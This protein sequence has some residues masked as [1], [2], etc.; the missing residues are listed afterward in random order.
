M[1]RR[2]PGLVARPDDR[3]SVDL[4]EAKGL[5]SDSRGVAV[6]TM[7]SRGTGLVRVVVTGATLGP[8][9]FAN[10]FQTT[11]LVPNITFEVAAGALLTAL[12]VP[13]LVQAIEHA[14]LGRAQEIA[15][16]LLGVVIVAFLAA[17]ALVLAAGP[18]IVRLLTSA[19]DDPVVASTT[20]REVWVLLALVAPQIALYGVAGIG[21]AAQNSR[22]QFA[23]AAAAPALENIGLIVTLLASAAWFGVGRD[24][25][26]VP[27]AELV[28]LGLGS[29]FAVAAHAALQLFGARRAGIRLRPRW[30]WNDPDVRA[31][32]RRSVPAVGAGALTGVWTFSV[33]VGAGVVPGGVIAFQVALSFYNLAMAIGARAVGTATLPRLA[34][35]GGAGE[36]GP[37]RRVYEH[38]LLATWSVALPAAVGVA[39]LARPLATALAF[40]RIASP[41]GIDLLSFA[42]ASLGFALAGGSVF[43]FARQAAYARLDTRSPL[44]AAA[45]RTT[46]TL[47]GVAIAYVGMRGS[48]SA[49]V[50]IGVAVTVGDS[51]A[52]W[53]QHRAVI[54]GAPPASTPFRSALRRPVIMTLVIAGPSIVVGRV[55]AARIEGRFGALLALAV[56]GT[57]SL[58]AYGAAAR[59]GRLPGGVGGIAPGPGAIAEGAPPHRSGGRQ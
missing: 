6:W 32:L 19:I 53:F 11:N 9:F 49:L 8:T 56:A 43:E 50:A 55:I 38:G 59:S 14:G 2:R 17:G 52:A 26:A 16:G 5:D 21:V 23:L 36:L 24:G 35:A 25:G 28:V 1:T 41:R 37:F 13:P 3:R 47:V 33:L 46:V 20:R 51:V 39:L 44:I 48:A 22:R 12:V 4:A 31:I 40:G 30:G 58:A 57:L 15:S 45:T 10:A 34:R 27:T 18:L 54:T 7:V 29:T 42:L